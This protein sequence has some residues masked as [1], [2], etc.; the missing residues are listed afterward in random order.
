MDL[1]T[2]IQIDSPII[3][4][5]GDKSQSLLIIL[6]KNRSLIIK[7]ENLRYFSKEIESETYYDQA[8]LTVKQTQ[9]DKYLVSTFLTKLNNKTYNTGYVGLNMIKGK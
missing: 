4:I 9:V 7:K 8:F 5:I 3:Q 1:L 6:P 2:K